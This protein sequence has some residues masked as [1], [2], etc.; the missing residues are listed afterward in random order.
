MRNSTPKHL[1]NTSKSRFNALPQPLNPKKD[2]PEGAKSFVYKGLY[3]L[4]I[5]KD[6]SCFTID[7]ALP[8]VV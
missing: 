5:L 8:R 6:F 2:G 7:A 4:K 3:K 1:A